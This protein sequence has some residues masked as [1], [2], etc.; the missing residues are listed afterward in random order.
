MSKNAKNSNNSN[1]SPLRQLTL[2]FGSKSGTQSSPKTITCSECGMIYNSSSKED[3]K[4]HEKHHRSERDKELNYSQAHSKHENLVSNYPNGKCVVISSE[5]SPKS[6]INKAMQV[7]AYVDKDLGIHETF[8][9]PPSMAKFYLF[10]SSSSNKIEGFCLAEPIKEAY[11]GSSA[12]DK[13]FTYDET[14]PEK[15]SNLCGISRIWVSSAM[16][17]CGIATRLLDCVC[18]NFFYI[19]RLEPK[20]LAF[21]DPTEFGQKLARAYTKSET[22]LVYKHRIG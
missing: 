13:C 5:T 3:E 16:R 2:N 18:A 1:N 11:W 19:M 7:L 20:Q 15:G 8:Q 9:R 22:F 12:S 10:V 21:S 4:L 6:V 17:R 14:K